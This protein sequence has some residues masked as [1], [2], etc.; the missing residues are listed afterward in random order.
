V[1]GDVH[2]RREPTIHATSPLTASPSIV[3]VACVVPMAC[4]VPRSRKIQFSQRSW[5]SGDQPAAWRR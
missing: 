3:I 5:R 1:A 4:P 2:R